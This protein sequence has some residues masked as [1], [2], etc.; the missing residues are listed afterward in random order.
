MNI[1]SMVAFVLPIAWLAWLAPI[2]FGF[3]ILVPGIYLGYRASSKLEG[4]GTHM[5]DEAGR[6]SSHIMWWGFGVAIYILANILFALVRQ[7]GNQ[8]A[9]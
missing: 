4:G 7:T 9:Y 6:A 3:M 8:V 1:L 2:P 5:A